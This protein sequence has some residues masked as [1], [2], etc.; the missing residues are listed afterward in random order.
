MNDST[1]ISQERLE[2][3]V[4]GLLS[5]AEAEDV[6]SHLAECE[7]CLSL[8]DTL[9]TSQPVGRTLSESVDLDVTTAERLE[10]R[11]VSR[12]HRS[13]LSGAVVRLGTQ[14]FMSVALGLLRPLIVTRRRSN[15]EQGA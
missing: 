11:L 2:Q 15:L 8:T 1:H 14:G 12:I 3:F 7:Q 5:E 10:R 9:W 6:M 4:T 13:N